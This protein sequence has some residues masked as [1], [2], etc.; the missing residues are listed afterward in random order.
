MRRA[1][2]TGAARGIGRSVAEALRDGGYEVIGTSRD[3]GGLSDP[4]AGIRFLSLDLTDGDSIA[5]CVE[6]AGSID[7]L[8][9]NAGFSLAGPLVETPWEETEALIAANWTGVVRLTRAMIP[10]MGPGGRIV[11]VGSLAARIPLPYVAVYAGLKG[12]LESFTKALRLELA[13]LGI[14]VCIVHPGFVNTAIRQDLFVD[15]DS[16]HAARV[17]KVRSFRAH[18][19][20]RGTKPEDVATVVLAAAR[21]EDPKAVWIAG[22]GARLFNV[23]CR[24]LPAG[25]FERIYRR[26]ISI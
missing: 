6:Q 10:T 8:V 14:T 19:M 2:V 1:L 18:S 5:A 25:L 24:L 17:A 23:L 13:P 3:P 15:P 4:P 16:P 11:T 12:G 26:K 21:T 22:R 7:L 9:N 20:A